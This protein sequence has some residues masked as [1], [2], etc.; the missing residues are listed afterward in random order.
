M[1]RDNVHRHDWTPCEECQ[2]CEQNPVLNLTLLQRYHVKSTHRLVE[3][4]LSTQLKHNSKLS[5]R[6]QQLKAM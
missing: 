3:D 5:N 4:L 6:L 1:N 2:T